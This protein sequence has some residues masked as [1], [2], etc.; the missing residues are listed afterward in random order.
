MVRD[1]L[2]P[3]K[4]TSI[5]VIPLVMAVALPAASMR[6]TSGFVLDQNGIGPD[7]GT[8]SPSFTLVEKDTRSPI[9]IV[10]RAGRI[11]TERTGARTDCADP[12]VSVSGPSVLRQV[13][14]R[15]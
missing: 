6:M 4:T 1:V 13:D 2:R 7:G 10:S 12:P 8:P 15:N 9:R 11:S 3:L 5:V 14:Q